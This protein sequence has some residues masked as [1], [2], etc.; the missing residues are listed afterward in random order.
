MSCHGNS[1][2]R[3]SLLRGL[4]LI[5]VFTI[6]CVAWADKQKPA[7]KPAPQSKP[8]AR[9][10][11]H[12]NSAPG[13]SHGAAQNRGSNPNSGGNNSRGGMNNNNRGG[14]N[15]NNRGAM[16][17]N[18]RGG[19]NN[20]NRGAMNN[21]NRGGMNNN[22]RG[23][24]NNNNRGGMNNNNRGGMNNNHGGMNNAHGGMNGHGGMNNGH[25]GMNASRRG[26]AVT[27]RE[28]RTRSGA[29]VHASFRGGHVRSIQAHNMRIDR[30]IHGNRR[31]VAEHNGRRIVSMG[32]HRGYSQRAYYSHG[33][34]A[35]VQRTY[36]VGGRRYAY[37]YRS[38]NY[39]GHPY[40]GYA[41]AYYYHPVYYGWAY[42][43]WPAPVPYRWAYYND[44]WY[45]AYGY[46][47]QP[48]PVYPSA[49][50]WLTDYLIAESLR[51]SYEAQQSGSLLVPGASERTG[52]DLMAALFSSDPLVN[53]NLLA[54]GLEGLHAIPAAA[55]GAQLSPEA[56]QA[57]AEEVKSQI[58]AEKDA[59]ENKSASGDDSTPAALDPNHHT[60][61]VA[62]EVDTSDDD[63][64]DCALTAG[65]VIYRTGDTPDD[66]NNVSAT[67]K[68]S[69]KDDCK[70]GA[71]VSVD[72]DDLQEMHNH[73]RET[74]DAGLKDLASKQGKGGLP[75]APDT[76]TSAGE[77]PAPAADTNVDSDLAQTQ[78]DADQTEADVQ[79]S[80]DSGSQQQQ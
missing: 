18:N 67:V 11:P 68:S 74:L 71:N 78:K 52:D 69:K 25:G 51:A 28:I 31:I 58:G 72:A 47:Y 36:Y 79:S 40:Y 56:K 16:N 27:N 43:P 61:V 6:A 5:L 70:V 46:Y 35:Y 3:H 15:N 21:N 57:I 48:Y 34:R 41:P 66:D 49:A 20:N 45:G 1:D 44:P 75:A 33:G 50:L 2:D 13:N 65:D 19:M 37:A 77:V 60:F 30:G 22:N 10:A 4:F 55:S 59:A 7:P 39:H 9:P 54:P 64:N 8:A 14:M 63:G 80:G 73:L 32:P 17:N 38:Y 24:M 76:G 53:A 12:A 62:S 29:T 26:P 23:G 42:N